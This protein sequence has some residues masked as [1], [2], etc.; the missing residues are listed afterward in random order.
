MRKSPTAQA[1]SA[2]SQPHQV[3][4]VLRRVDGPL[5]QP[6][7]LLVELGQQPGAPVAG[8]AVSLLGHGQ[9]AQQASHS[10]RVAHPRG[11]QQRHRCRGVP[12]QAG[13][14]AEDDRGDRLGETDDG[15]TSAG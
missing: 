12:G 15:E 3:H 6:A 2:S 4:E 11:P 9:P 5:G 13:Q 7:D 14:I 1:R 8:F 10:D